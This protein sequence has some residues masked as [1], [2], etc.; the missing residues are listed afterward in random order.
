M[1][2]KQKLMMVASAAVV[3]L[4]MTLAGCTGGPGPEAPPA[5]SQSDSG[6]PSDA[7]S[8]GE[9]DAATPQGADLAVTSFAVSWTDA[10]DTAMDNFD[11]KLAEIE[12]DWSRDRYAYKIELVSAAEE[13]ELRIDADTGEQ[14][15]EHTEALEPDDLAEKQTEVVD[16][17]A[18]I[19]WDEALAAALDAQSGTI[20]E[21]MLEGTEHGPQ[22]QFDVDDDSGE[23]YEISIDART[24]DL[25][26]A[27]D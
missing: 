5:T 14:F 18:I 4:S 13:Y 23:D 24:G 12:L 9:D 27:D 2:A 11:G 10:V 21:W 8:D 25:L 6:A 15:E 19:P 22:Y 7:P 1:R 26:G 16:L 20:N 17:D 3:V